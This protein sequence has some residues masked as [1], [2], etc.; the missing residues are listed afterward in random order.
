M[1]NANRMTMTTTARRLTKGGPA[2]LAL[3]FAAV[4][5][6]GAQQTLQVDPAHASVKF[7]LGD[8]L[9]TVRG[10]FAVKRGQLQLDRN[11]GKLT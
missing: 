9:H 7:T 10:T 1:G 4:L 6:A 5:S 11:A 3:L 2:V 8:V